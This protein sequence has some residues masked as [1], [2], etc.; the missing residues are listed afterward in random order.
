[1]PAIEDRAARLFYD[2]ACG[3]CTVLAR[4]AEGVSRHRLVAVP[5][6]GP[7]ADV[8][9]GGLA[10]ELRFGYAHLEDGTALRTGSSAATPLVS[11][12]S[13]GLWARLTERLPPLDRAV[14]SVY[15]HLWE[16]R[17]SRGCAAARTGAGPGL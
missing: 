17:R 4:A 3:P 11:L 12:L 10:P 5:L 9:L 2:D 15:D 7:E 8:R 6:A 16:Y 13:G 1:M 14:R